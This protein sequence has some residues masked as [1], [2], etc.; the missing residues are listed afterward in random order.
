LAGDAI[1][2][3]VEGDMDSRALFLLTAGHLLDQAAEVGSVN[4]QLQ[5]QFFCRVS[6]ITQT[7]G[8]QA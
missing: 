3:S 6:L 1:V 7:K 8:L 2:S 4:K 5:I